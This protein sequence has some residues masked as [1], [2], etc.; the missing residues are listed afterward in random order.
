MKHLIL[1]ELHEI[2]FTL[3]CLQV[4]LCIHTGRVTTALCPDPTEG[5]VTP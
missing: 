4:G 5:C 1:F 3:L 2:T